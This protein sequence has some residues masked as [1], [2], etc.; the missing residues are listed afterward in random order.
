ML[1]Y[2][3]SFGWFFFQLTL[4]DLLDL[5][6]SREQ[7]IRLLPFINF[8]TYGEGEGR[9]N[10]LAFGWLNLEFS[11]MVLDIDHY[12]DQLENLLNEAEELQKEK[13][14]EDEGK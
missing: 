3:F 4:L 10:V 12:V 13:D 1:E 5:R 2:G 11:I 8:I 14:S 6:Y 9:V 7:E